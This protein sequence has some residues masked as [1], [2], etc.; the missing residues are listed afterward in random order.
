MAVSIMSPQRWVSSLENIIEAYKK[1][2]LL[3]YMSELK[4]FTDDTYDI[5]KGAEERFY[6]LQE[7]IEQHVEDQVNKAYAYSK[8]KL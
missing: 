1:D 3:E 5:N 6:W 4:K 2:Q 8:I 7:K